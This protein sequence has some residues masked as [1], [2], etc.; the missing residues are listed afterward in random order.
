MRDPR[1]LR[2]TFGVFPGLEIQRHRNADVLSCFLADERT[3][4]DNQ[5][6]STS[7]P[8]RRRRRKVFSFLAY[9]LTLVVSGTNLEGKTG[10][11][12]SQ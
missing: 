4:A 8:A 5:A 2:I 7:P 6:V 11:Q 3:S 10:A 1:C 12:A 9:N